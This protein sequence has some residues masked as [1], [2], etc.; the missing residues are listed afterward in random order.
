MRRSTFRHRH[1]P[2]QRPR[3]RAPLADDVLL[4]KRQLK[5]GCH[6]NRHVA[7]AIIAAANRH[8]N[9][10]HCLSRRH[11]LFASAGIL[12]ANHLQSLDKSCA[13]GI[14]E[15][16]A[17][18][19]NGAQHRHGVMRTAGA[20]LAA[21]DLR[22]APQLE[23]PFDVDDGN[24]AHQPIAHSAFDHLEVVRISL[25]GIALNVVKR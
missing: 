4:P 1:R 6:S 17:E 19:Q 7:A 13:V 24:H 3:D 21:L 10:G 15:R 22:C 11:L 23:S 14:T 16:E 5:L 8:A 9:E 25:A 18:P 2:R 20:G 12:E